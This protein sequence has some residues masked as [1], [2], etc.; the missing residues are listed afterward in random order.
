LVRLGFR[1]KTTSA[2]FVAYASPKM[3]TGRYVSTL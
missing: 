3:R 2:T 1:I